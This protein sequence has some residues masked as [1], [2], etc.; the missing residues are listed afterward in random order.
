MLQPVQ[1]LSRHDGKAP[2][3]EYCAGTGEQQD[4]R[5]H[6]IVPGLWNVVPVVK[7]LK[8]RPC[9]QDGQECEHNQCDCFSTRTGK[10]A[11]HGY[12]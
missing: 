6:G 9:Q 2:N 11:A 3:S 10:G 8:Y 12:V 5:Q 4:N 7:E 1:E